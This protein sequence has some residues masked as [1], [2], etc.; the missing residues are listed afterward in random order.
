MA[1]VL[2]LFAF[3]YS[4]VRIVATDPGGNLAAAEVAV[5]SG[6]WQPLD[7]LD[8][9]ADSPEETYL[10]QIESSGVADVTGGHRTIKVRVTDS[11]GNVGGDAWSLDP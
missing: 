9:V 11:A 4:L 5:D 3:E 8:G 2:A 7:P 1:V 10:L 6:D